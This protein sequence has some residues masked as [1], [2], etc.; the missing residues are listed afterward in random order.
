M[1]ACVMLASGRLHGLFVQDKGLLYVVSRRRVVPASNKTLFEKEGRTFR[2][3]RFREALIPD[4]G[5]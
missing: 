2:L 3:G 1:S 4:G 5:N